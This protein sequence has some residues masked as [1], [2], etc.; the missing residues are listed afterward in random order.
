MQILMRSLT[1]PCLAINLQRWLPSKAREVM[2]STEDR[3]IDSGFKGD[4]DSTLS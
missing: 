2:L 1:P 4:N 3:K